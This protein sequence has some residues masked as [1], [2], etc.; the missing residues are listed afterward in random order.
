MPQDFRSVWGRPQ[1][2]PDPQDVL[3]PAHNGRQVQRLLCTSLQGILLSYPG[4]PLSPVLFNVV[5]NTA[6]RNWVTV[7]AAPEAVTEGLGLL[8]RDLAV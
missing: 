8:I 1:G 4:R 7:L 5:M 2:A 6:I 3:V